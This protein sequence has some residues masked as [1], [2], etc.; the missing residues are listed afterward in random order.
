[1]DN[2]SRVLWLCSL[3]SLTKNNSRTIDLA[4]L[5]DKNRIAYV[6]ANIELQCFRVFISHMDRKDMKEPSDCSLSTT[7]DGEDSQIRLACFPPEKYEQFKLETIIADL[8]LL[9]LEK[10][11]ELM[12]HFEE[13][14]ELT[15]EEKDVLCSY[16]QLLSL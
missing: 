5:V 13:D 11:K 16:M 10:A 4:G 15:T 7:T 9:P 1:M 8:D 14:A 2:S 6:D 3:F 12:W